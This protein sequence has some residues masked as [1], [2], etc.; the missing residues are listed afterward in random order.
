LPGYT[1]GLPGYDESVRINVTEDYILKDADNVRKRYV[2]NKW[3]NKK[4]DYERYLVNGLTYV[5]INKIE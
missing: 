4:V 2:G 3:V 1:D 5:T